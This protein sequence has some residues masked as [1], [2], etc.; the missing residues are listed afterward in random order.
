MKKFPNLFPKDIVIPIQRSRLIIR[1]GKWREI[2]Y[3]GQDRTASGVY[4]FVTTIEGIV[5]I[6]KASAKV[7]FGG[8]RISHI[9]LAL[10]RE[11][12]YAGR[13]S[14]SGRNNRGFLRKWTN[15]SGHY[16]PTPEFIGNASLP[17]EF[18]E[19]GQFTNLISVIS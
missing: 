19:A 1:D 17:I 11:V 18:F 14:F 12:N 3:N 13:I 8:R 5:L 15:E 16:R 7:G 10:G 9:D 6:R 2:T 4:N